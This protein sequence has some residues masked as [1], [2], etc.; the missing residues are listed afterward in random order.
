MFE[1]QILNVETNEQFLQDF[2]KKSESK[3]YERESEKTFPLA[4]VKRCVHERQN[5]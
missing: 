4:T 2:V 3:I 5:I 1:L